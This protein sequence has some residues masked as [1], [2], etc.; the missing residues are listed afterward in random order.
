MFSNSPE[1]DSRGCACRV[2][3]AKE[4]LSSTDN[5]NATRIVSVCSPK[6]HL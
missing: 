3:E 6:Q 4:S 5:E 1:I 2:S